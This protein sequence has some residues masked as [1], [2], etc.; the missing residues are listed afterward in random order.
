VIIY[1]GV[2]KLRNYYQ[3]SEE[4]VIEYFTSS[5]EKGLTEKEVRKRLYQYGLNKIKETDG[6][7]I[8]GIFFDQFRD[9]MILILMV[10]TLLSFLMGEVGDG[11]TIFAII[12]LNGIMG[13]IQEYKAEKS[14]AAL[15]R[16]TAPMTRV[17]REGIAKRIDAEELVPGDLLLLESGDKVPADARIITASGL[18]VDESLLTGES[19]PV[20]KTENVLY[21]GDLEPAQCSNMLFMGTAIARGKCR[22]IIVSTGMDTEMGKIAELLDQDQRTLTPLQKRLKHLGKW[23]VAISVLITLAIVMIGILKG[24]S[25]YQMFLAG[26]SLAVAAIPEG[27]PAIVTLALAMG[28]QKMIKNNAI[29]RRLQAVETLG[30][31]TVVCADKTGTL[32]RNQMAVSKYY[33]NHRINRFDS[34]IEYKEIEKLLKI[35]AICN[36]VQLKEKERQ[37]PISKVKKILIGKQIPELMGDPTEI[38]LVEAIYQYNFT[39]SGLRDEYRLVAEEDFDATRKR[40]SVIIE[41][42]DQTKELWLKGAPET[43]L[44][45]C[46]YLDINGHLEELSAE[47]K[48]EV[49]KA[50][51]SMAGEAL[52][53]LA[54]AYRLLSGRVNKKNP[55]GLEKKLVLV[56]L[57]GLI[58]PPRPEVYQAVQDCYRAGIRPVMITG[59]HRIT[60]RVIA[61]EIGIIPAKGRVITG[62][63]LKG[64]NESRFKK[65]VE[66]V[67]VYARMTGDGVNDA[68]AVKEADIGISMG[69]KGTDV[70]KEVSSLILA[71]DNFATI[72]KAIAEGRKIYNNIRKF[73]RYLLS[74]N[75]GELLTIFM[76]IVMGLPLPLIPIQILWVNL[77]TDGLPALALG[78]DEDSDDVMSD[79][80]RE[81]SEGIFAHGMIS[82]IT[83]QGVLIGVSTITAFLLAIYRLETGLDV[84]RTMAFSTLVFSQLFFVFSCRSEDHVFWQLS[85]FSNPYLLLAVIISALMQ[86]AVIY[87][88]FL[89]VFFQTMVLNR[90]EWLIVFVLSI[91]STII[92]DFVRY[93][94]KSLVKS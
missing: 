14:L 79:P 47:M 16:M 48:E 22:A 74:C 2:I 8:V 23:L 33:Y 12:I 29:V 36:S 72:V 45:R 26:V 89:S 88:P 18:Q 43:V 31:A 61:E 30:C 25:I 52:R 10:A 67:Q 38:A 66:E 15:K 34:K 3:L 54:L 39:L 56:G 81:P 69:K 75:T 90:G 41:K 19:M 13:F 51:E 73:I 11:I 35:G 32:T 4:A 65:L 55:A 91:W 24:Q 62:E 21:G 68:P 7:G 20:D 86:F 17:I 27:L 42:S 59:D 40:M 92:L 71:D 58:D 6:K 49:L 85:P 94:A 46:D 70:T 78:L 9:F 63:D 84:A 77:V 76:G 5:G 60:A 50:N 82:N 93:F 57:V 64:I 44:E 37:G 87:L 53:V 28:V 83:S 80:P 1:T